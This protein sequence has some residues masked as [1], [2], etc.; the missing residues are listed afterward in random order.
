MLTIEKAKM[1][2]LGQYVKVNN[3]NYRIDDIAEGTFAYKIS[4]HSNVFDNTIVMHLYRNAYY[5]SDAG[6]PCYKI[7]RYNLG[8]QYKFSTISIGGLSDK[9]QF[10]ELLGKYIENANN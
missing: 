1:H 6:Q 10:L 4:L 2:L 5:V 9:E 3:V 7:Q 8:N